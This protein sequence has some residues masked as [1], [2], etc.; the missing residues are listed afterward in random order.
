MF[1]IFESS[2]TALCGTIGIFYFCFFCD[3]FCE[4]RLLVAGFPV[5]FDPVPVPWYKL[6]SLGLP[7]L[8]FIPKKTK[9]GVLSEEWESPIGPWNPKGNS[10]KWWNLHI[11]FRC[12]FHTSKS[13]S[14]NRSNWK[15]IVGPCGGSPDSCGG[16]ESTPFK[17]PKH[18]S[19][20]CVND[21][22]NIFSFNHSFDR[23]NT[24]TFV[25]VCFFLGWRRRIRITSCNTSGDTQIS[26]RCQLVA[27]DL[28]SVTYS[29]LTTLVA[30][31]T[32]RRSLNAA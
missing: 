13:F 10:M 22:S 30:L 1:P 12:F 16:G 27:L 26:L 19:A 15:A 24:R 5:F 25:C 17:W 23:R 11:V 3:V 29:F 28:S 7:C 2:A 21:F 20:S 14:F 32:G 31:E 18:M 6:C 8:L 9:T 4:D